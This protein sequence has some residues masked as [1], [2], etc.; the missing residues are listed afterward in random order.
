MRQEA[1]GG[2]GGGGGG[3]ALSRGRRGVEP[4]DLGGGLLA[5]GVEG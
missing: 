2:G 4:A 5:R 1:R 3:G